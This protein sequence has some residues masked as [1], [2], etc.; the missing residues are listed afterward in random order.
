MTDAEKA[1]RRAYLEYISATSP[2]VTVDLEELQAIVARLKAARD[3][4]REERENG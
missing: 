3:R 4:V 2:G 1:F